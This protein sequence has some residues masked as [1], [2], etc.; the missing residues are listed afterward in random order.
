MLGIET[1]EPIRRG[2]EL[3]E[4]AAGHAAPLAPANVLKLTDAG[5]RRRV[6]DI[7]IRSHTVQTL[8][9]A[10]LGVGVARVTEEILEAVGR[11]V[12]PSLDGIVAGLQPRFEELT[13]PLVI[14]AREYGF[15]TDTTSDDVIDMGDESASAAWRAVPRAW[16]ALSPLVNF[17]ISMTE[18]FEL[19]PTM[20]QT[21]LH[22]LPRHPGKTTPNLSVLFAAGDNWSLG[23]GYYI[24]GK[25]VGH[26]DW[27]LM[28]REGLRL[29]TPSEVDAKLASRPRSFLG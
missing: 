14:A 20:E 29:N 3:I 18:V 25:T 27:L 7:S 26:L 9:G 12:V 16:S 11:E 5:L 23:D 13:A 4:I 17:R 24:D 10:G 22:Y 15:T 28:A 19:A 21:R 1:P 8:H 2:L 6:E